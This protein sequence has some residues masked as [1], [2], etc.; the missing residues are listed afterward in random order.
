MR[1]VFRRTYHDEGFLN[2]M[3]LLITI[4]LTFIRDYTI[5]IGEMAAWERQRASFIPVTQVGAFFYLN[6]NL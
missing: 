1:A 5:P 6:G 3:M 4:P 2:T